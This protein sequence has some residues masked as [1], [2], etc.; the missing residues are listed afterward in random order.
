MP[1]EPVIPSVPR[2]FVAGVSGSISESHVESEVP[3]EDC[4]DIQE[5]FEAFT[6]SG[7]AKRNRN[8]RETTA[9][10]KPCQPPFEKISN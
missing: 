10:S 6:L 4:D 1:P 3:K 5:D 7:H 2:R 9:N 8:D